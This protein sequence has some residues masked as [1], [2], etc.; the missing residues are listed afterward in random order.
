MFLEYR[1]NAHLGAYKHIKLLEKKGNFYHNNTL[2]QRGHTYNFHA[3]RSTGC[4]FSGF[5]ARTLL[6][7]TLLANAAKTCGL[8]RVHKTKPTLARRLVA[9]SM[10]RIALKN[11][12]SIIG[13]G[14]KIKANTVLLKVI[15]KEKLTELHGTAS[16]ISGGPESGR[17][18]TGCID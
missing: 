8:L 14:N 11:R 10:L 3:L 1:I 2:K 15:K 6:A 4:N 7:R 16:I 5:L 13:L 12:V 18:R 9:R 17:P